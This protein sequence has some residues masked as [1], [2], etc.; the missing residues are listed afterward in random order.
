MHTLL[1][2]ER[3]PLNY[4]EIASDTSYLVLSSE[5]NEYMGTKLKYDQNQKRKQSI[6]IYDATTTV[7][8]RGLD[9][10]A[11]EWSRLSTRRCY[12]Y[13]HINVYRIDKHVDVIN[14][15]VY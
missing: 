11:V 10:D 4:R 9:T 2:F 14:T 6:Q 3:M 5:S 8:Q 1:D 7:Y 15:C 13:L 12:F